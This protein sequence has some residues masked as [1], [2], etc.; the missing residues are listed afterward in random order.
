MGEPD[1]PLA[2]RDL[3]TRGVITLDPQA[4]LDEVSDLMRAHRIR[5]VPIVDAA[6]H[7]L[8]L[9]THRDLLG[10]A[11]GGGQDLPRSIRQPYLRS[12][13]VG[14]VMTRRVV[15][16]EPDALLN[17]VARMMVARRLGCLPVVEGNRVIGILTATDFVRYVAGC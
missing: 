13:P 4:N 15:T 11:F 5:H 17:D 7:L 10:K 6:G 8:G 9:V 1:Q 2:V 16:V 14:E 3:M 12:I